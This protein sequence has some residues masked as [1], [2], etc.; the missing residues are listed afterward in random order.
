MLAKISIP[1]QLTGGVEATIAY[2]SDGQFQSVYIYSIVELFKDRNYII[3]LDEPDSFLHPEWQFDFLKQ[4][5]EITEAAS[6]KNDVLLS[7]HSASTISSAPESVIN[8]FDLDGTQIAVKKINKSD[9]IKSLSS[10]LITFS[11][12]EARL[13]IHHVLKNNTGTNATYLSNNLLI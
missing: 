13:D 6:K 2:F 5:F 9:V 3:L 8:L 1:L 10:G 11:E 12:S 4:V 7:S